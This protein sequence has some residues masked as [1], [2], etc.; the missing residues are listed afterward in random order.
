MQDTRIF[1]RN[2]LFRL[3]KSSRIVDQSLVPKA[4][5]R[6]VR[7]YS[8]IFVLGHIAAFSSLI[9]IGLPTT[10]SYLSL[11][12]N[13]LK[14]G[15][16]SNPYAFIDALVMLAVVLGFQGAGFGLWIRSLY[17]RKRKY[18]SWFILILVVN[19]SQ[20]KH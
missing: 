8:V 5:M 4:E 14:S 12:F 11:F 2:Q 15:Y 7:W 16:Q 1:T 18:L 3:L 20:F 17:H 6:V 13:T 10:F 9:L 19:L